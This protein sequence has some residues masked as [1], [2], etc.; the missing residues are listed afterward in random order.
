[1]A[2]IAESRTKDV[3]FFFKNDRYDFKVFI[4]NNRAGT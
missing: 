1:M 2:I 3:F 4:A